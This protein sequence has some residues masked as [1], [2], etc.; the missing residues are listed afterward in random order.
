MSAH[1]QR[2]RVALEDSEAVLERARRWGE[3]LAET[4]PRG[5]RLLVAGNGGSAAQAQHLTAEL[6]G[7]YQQ[8]RPAFSAL[9]LHAETSSMTAIL[10]DYGAAE[11]FARQVR[12][13][14]RPGDVCLLMSTSGRSPNVI[15]A[16]RAARELGLR[17][18]ALCGRG[19]NP[20]TEVADEALCITAEDTATVQE[21]H[22]VALHMV[23]EAFDAALLGEPRDG[24]EPATAASSPE[25]SDRSAGTPPKQL[26]VVGDALLD[27]DVQASV[28]RFVPDHAAP[29]LDEVGRVQRPGGAAL[30]A[31]LAA[32]DGTCAVTLVAAVADDAA[33][34]TLRGLLAGRVRLIA[35]PCRGAT[36]VKT[37]LHARGTV[38]ARLDQGGP[39]VEVSGVPGAAAEALATADVVL[40]SDY[41]RGVTPALLDLLRQAAARCPLVWD[42][43]PRGARPVVGARLVTPNIAEAARASASPTATTVAAACRQAQRLV[44]EWG[45]GGVAL[46]MGD[47][48]AV[49]ASG[50]ES[51]AAFP[52]A[53]P[54]VSD[55]CGA[56]DRFAARLA[57]ALAAGALPSEA[58]AAA[59]ESAS[60]FIA[61]GGV[62]AL[63]LGTASQSPASGGAASDVIAAV[64]A[65]GGTVVATGGCFDILHAGH[66]A[67]L[68]AAR[69]LGD[70]LIVCVNSD[71]SVRRTKGDARPLQ[72]V[73]DRVRLLSGLRCVDAVVVF[74]EDTPAAVLGDLRP[75]VWVKGGDYAGAPMPESELVRSWGGEVV[76]VPYLPGRS[77]TRLVTLAR[78]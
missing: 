52:V 54:V 65:A 41:G 22:L 69:A 29:V 48:G 5:A 23:C 39:G 14:G 20:L 42:P 21:L 9:A 62:A 1:V 75:D 40:V 45:V 26:V 35:L 47:R 18:W 16:A 33:G 43:H 13:H 68:G 46:T 2:L 19:P 44:G 73:A 61:A 74:D 78:S 55:A 36:G 32:A 57:T 50:A 10:N 11:V 71:D 66:V 51:T 60:R 70:C 76:T 6:V 53:A 30:A 77:T 24:F 31:L 59:V 15:A 8:E 34:A 67:T 64:R 3:Q 37:R 38:L 63:A 25:L 49:L 56:G 27:V 17:V 7:R 4:L 72:P 28:E 12:A 58:V